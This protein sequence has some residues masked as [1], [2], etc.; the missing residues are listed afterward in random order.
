MPL[1]AVPLLAGAAGEAV[2]ARTLRFLLAR[3]LAEKKE[4]EQRKAEFA[5]QVEE[6]RQASLARARELHGSK[7]KRKRRRKKKLPLTSSCT[8]RGVLV[9][10]S[11]SGM[12][13]MLGF[14]GDVPLR[15][16]FPSVVVR[17]KMLGIMAGMDQKDSGALIVVSCSDM[18]KA[19]VAGFTPRYVF[20]LVVGKPAG[21]SVWT[22]RTFVQLAGFT[23]DDTS[24]AVFSSFSSGPD[25]RHLGRYEPAGL[26]QGGAEADSHGLCC[27]SRPWRFP[28]CSSTGR[29]SS[30]RGAEVFSHGPDCCRTMEIP[31]FVDT[32]AD[33]PVV[34]SY[35][36]SRAG[37]EETFVLPQLQLVENFDGHQHPCLGANAASHGFHLLK[38]IE[39]PQL[40]FLTR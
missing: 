33:V 17:P 19:R 22:R 15:A 16:V 37:V 3:S 34:Q 31:Q 39:I 7:R 13:A 5:R 4:E 32:V 28:S 2:D 30:R 20:P 21:R 23:G 11:G 40:E 35:R 38:T 26:L 25:A 36:F 6:L 18:C 24:C 1:L 8:F 27:S 29:S 10:D 9:V 14:P 12:L